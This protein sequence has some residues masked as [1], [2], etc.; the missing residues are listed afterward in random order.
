MATKVE[1]TPTLTGDDADRFI[2]KLN[3]TKYN[4]YFIFLLFI[5]AEI[6]LIDLI[7]LFCRNIYFHLCVKKTLSLVSFLFCF[8]N[9]QESHNNTKFHSND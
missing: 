4:L 9:F 2:Q 3:I 6:P 5:Q 8:F 1:P 7:D